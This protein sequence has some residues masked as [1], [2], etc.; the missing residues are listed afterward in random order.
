MSSLRMEKRQAALLATVYWIALCISKLVFIV[1]SRY[2]GE[3]ILIQSCTL[4]F[5]I[6]SI[7][8]LTVANA[9]EICYWLVAIFFGWGFGP[10]F[11]LSYSELEKYFH[12]TGKHTS[13]IC[14]AFVVGE[15]IHVPLVGQFIEK[16]PDIFLYYG[17][18]LAAVFVMAFI[19][20]P[21]ICRSLFGDSDEAKVREITGEYRGSRFGSIMIPVT[22]R[23]ESMM[24]F[25][26]EPPNQRRPSTFSQA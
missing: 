25:G 13:V 1:L 23:R 26:A 6:G 3:K 11:V 22:E 7:L 12:L 5:L 20:L 21:F 2:T 4:I 18:T 15:A 8:S 24:S 19:A 10:L 14:I 16:N 9:F 17:G